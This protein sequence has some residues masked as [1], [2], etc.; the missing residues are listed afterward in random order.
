MGVGTENLSAGAA[1]FGDALK[2]TPKGAWEQLKGAFGKGEAV[3]KVLPELQ[4][5]KTPLWLKPITIPMN[6]GFKII[7][8]PF[9][10]AAA[11]TGV[12]LDK[13]GSAYRSQPLLMG[14][15]T[16][17]AAG[18]GINRLVKGS[19][20]QRTAKELQAEAMKLSAI[21]TQQPQFQPPVA[22]TYNYHNSVTP[23]ETAAMEARLAAKRDTAGH[24]A[25]VANR[26]EGATVQTEL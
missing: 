18:V 25:T 15:A 14:V 5:V 3:E 2:S 22:N 16:V 24:A 26:A 6:A 8:Y 12:G 20:E 11:Y 21:Q 10:K 4:A 19:A 23:E 7:K 17:A 9:S 1:R 13:L